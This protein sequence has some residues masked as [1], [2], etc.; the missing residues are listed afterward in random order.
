MNDDLTRPTAGQSLTEMRAARNNLVA[1]A[2]RLTADEKNWTEATQA[3]VEGLLHKVGQ[4]DV[5]IAN[6]GEWI[7]QQSPDDERR[8]S[9]DF[10]NV[11]TG[12]AIPVARAGDNFRTVLGAGREAYPTKGVFGL[13]DFVRGIAGMRSPERI[14]AALSE[15]TDSAGGFTL[16]AYLQLPMLEALVPNSSLLT[17]GAGIAMLDEG[18]KSYRIAA[19]STV[20]TAAWRAEGGTL[21]TSDP[22]FRNVDLVPRSLAFTFK[23]SRELLADA[24]NLEPALRNAIAQAFAKEIDRAGLR[25]TGTPPE[26]RGILNTTGIQAVSNGANG[27]TQATIKWANLHSAYQAIIG[28]NAPAPTA[29]IM[30]PRSLVGF[31]AFADTTGQPLNRPFL[32][33]DIKFIASSQIPVDLTVGSS[34]DCSEVFLGDFRSV[35]FFF[36]E[37]MSI[38]K[39]NELYAGTGEIGF[40]CHARV[41]VAVTYPAALAVVTG[42]RA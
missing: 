32:L 25:G 37:R 42:V 10:Y 30:A 29:A 41:D 34:T 26:I 24:V 40:A 1:E 13:S 8:A 4:I 27:A 21:A 3:K 28:A 31:S 23:V 20:P 17:A 12:R 9:G 39:L 18:A 16:P 33:N 14:R 7:S 11:E 5:E 19:V 22:T 35:V 15:G 36:R 2:R 6:L 38:Q